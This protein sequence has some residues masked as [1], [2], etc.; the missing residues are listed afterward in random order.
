MIRGTIIKRNFVN[1]GR[2]LTQRRLVSSKLKN[3][4]HL[5]HTDPTANPPHNPAPYNT[6]NY[7]VFL[8]ALG[9][10]GVAYIMYEPDP[11]SIAGREKQDGKYS[12]V[13]NAQN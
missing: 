9:I 5:K 10:G 7:L 4:D 11:Y 13:K 6:K 12:N 3:A 8:A 1:Q 2:V